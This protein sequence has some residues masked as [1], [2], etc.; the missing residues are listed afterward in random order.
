MADMGEEAVRAYW[1]GTLPNQEDEDMMYNKTDERETAGSRGSTMSL[2]EQHVNFYLSG[3]DVFTP[4]TLEAPLESTPSSNSATEIDF[5]RASVDIVNVDDNLTKTVKSLEIEQT[6]TVMSKE[7]FAGGEAVSLSKAEPAMFTVFR[8]LTRVFRRAEED[9]DTDKEEPND[10]PAEDTVIIEDGERTPR[11]HSTDEHTPKAHTPAKNGSGID[12]DDEEENRFWNNRYTRWNDAW[13]TLA[14]HSRD[15]S[16]TPPWER[17]NGKERPPRQESSNK[18][19]DTILSEAARVIIGPTDTPQHSEGDSDFSSE[20]DSQDGGS[21]MDDKPT[22]GKV[23]KPE[24]AG[25]WEALP[26]T[27]RS[28]SQ[29]DLYEFTADSPKFMQGVGRRLHGREPGMTSFVDP[30]QLT[31]A[32]LISGVPEMAN[33][34]EQWWINT[35][36]V[37]PENVRIKASLSRKFARLAI[38]SALPCIV[39]GPIWLY[40]SGGAHLLCSR[41]GIYDEFKSL[42]LETDAKFSHKLMKSYKPDQACLS[43]DGWKSVDRIVRCVAYRHCE[44]EDYC[45]WLA[46]VVGTCLHF[47]VEEEA[48]GV[49]CALIQEPS[50]LISRGSSW[51]MLK[52]FEQMV[53]QYLPT[54]YVEL[55]KFHGTENPELGP[56]H[57]LAGLITE[58]LQALPFW[59]LVRLLDVFIV[60]RSWTIFLRFGMAVVSSWAATVMHRPSHGFGRA[61]RGPKWLVPSASARAMVNPDKSLKL[62]YSAST[63]VTNAEVSRA[64]LKGHADALEDMMASG[65]FAGV[66]ETLETNTKSRAGICIPSV[67]MPSGVQPLV[68]R[69]SWE[70]LWPCIPTRFQLKTAVLC[71]S[72]HIHGYSLNTYFEQCGDEAPTILVIRDRDGYTFG[73]FLPHPWTEREENRRFFGSP[74]TFLISLRP[75]F[76][77]YRW[78]GL[79]TTREIKDPPPYFMLAQKNSLAIGGGG[80]EGYA[81]QL[82]DELRYG[83]SYPCDTFDNPKLTKENKF[84]CVAVEVWKFVNREKL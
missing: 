35:L 56:Q 81:I 52:V 3:S 31:N 1:E 29:P 83:S 78:V 15:T 43:A 33:T 60:E 4:T 63:R 16:P 17:N 25:S 21:G 46:L 2:D 27:K 77:H 53:K 58:W 11:A 24:S 80:G 38:K 10:D 74:E 50:P 12:S 40:A 39:R 67:V 57:P 45:P 84:E 9:D 49:A 28:D 51:L 68:Q 76:N 44:I 23:R 22:E 61:D 64:Q 30:S 6:E 79:D 13:A 70:E 69:D 7:D 75:E 5:Y 82:D 18:S 14:S 36:K 48:F 66:D 65:R 73:A 32:A 19:T 26:E 8:R 72:T 62:C 34:S 71:F 54:Q 37:L 47:M 20:V 41:P 59:T 42:N 55:C